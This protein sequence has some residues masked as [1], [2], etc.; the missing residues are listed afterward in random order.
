MTHPILIDTQ[1]TTTTRFAQF[2]SELM[3]RDLSQ[4]TLDVYRNCLTKYQ[5]WLGYS[6]ISSMSVKLFLSEL[7][8]RKYSPSTISLHYTILKQFLDYLG[9][10]LKL[11]LRQPHHLPQYHSTQQLTSML[12][13][14]LNAS[15]KPHYHSIRDTLI[16]LIL[17]LTGVRR[18]E[19]SRLTPADNL[20]GYIFIRNTKSNKDRSIPL[21]NRLQHLL[22]DYI[23]SHH[24]ALDHPIF[25]ISP[26]RIYAIVRN[27]SNKAGLSNI[28]PHSFRHYFA[29][30]L[31]EN[32]APLIAVQQLLGHSSIKTTAVYLD[33]VPRHLRQTIALF[34]QDKMLSTALTT[35][36]NTYTTSTN[37]NI[38]TTTKEKREKREKR[39]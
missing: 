26:D 24:I 1:I 35:I 16:I 10:P 21:H 32:G 30:T 36:N 9:I 6:P 31:I 5:N 22:H 28:T 34:D 19:L 25:P 2:T 8:Q 13:R 11:K 29:T 20:D 3:L 27:Y 37:N 33:L 38:I 18:A 39:K 23:S 4:N 7:R 17:A 15:T 12:D 14:A